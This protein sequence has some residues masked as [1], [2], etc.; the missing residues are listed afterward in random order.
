MVPNATV[1]VAPA[2]SE[3]LELLLLPVELALEPLPEAAEPDWAAA[4]ASATRTPYEVAMMGVP[5]DV[6]V[7]V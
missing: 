7:L 2:L 1:T 4:V 5:P 3:E 6:G